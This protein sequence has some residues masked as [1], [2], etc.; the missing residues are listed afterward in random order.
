MQHRESVIPGEYETVPL[1]AADT[2]HDKVTKARRQTAPSKKITDSVVVR[3][4]T[5]F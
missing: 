2:M 1:Y 5:V 4:M 3:H